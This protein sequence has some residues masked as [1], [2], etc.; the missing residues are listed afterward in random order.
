MSAGGGQAV[1]NAPPGVNNENNVNHVHVGPMLQPPPN[2]RRF[3]NQ[4]PLF[5]VRERLFHALFFKFAV[6][7]ARTFPR[8]VRRFFEFLVLLK[9]L[10]AF[11]VLAY[12]HIAFSRTPT[13]CL[14]HVKDSWPR[15]GILRVEILRN[16]S[17]DY[18]IEQSYA[19]ER[20]LKKDK[21]E[22]TTM[23]GMLT[24]EG[25]I[26]IESSADED[27]NEDE[28]IRDGTDYGNI[29]RVHEEG[30]DDTESRQ[31]IETSYINTGPDLISTD[32]TVDLNATIVATEDLE[33]PSSS[34]WEG[35]M[36]FVDEIEGKK[37]MKTSLEV[38]A[39]N[40]S[41]KD[42]DYILEYSLEYGFLRLSPSA[43]L[44]LKIPVKIVTLDPQ[45]DKC[46]GDTFSRFVLDEFLGYDD[47][48][49]A[50]I[51]TL[52]ENEDNKGYLR[53]VITG[54]HYRF[55]SMLTARSS[56]VAAFFIM[57]VFTVSISMLLRYAHHQ[58]FVFIVDLLQMLEFNVTVTFP[59]APLLT[60]ILALVGM[61][62]IMSEFFN[63]TTTAFYIILIVWIADQ[64]DAICCHTAIAKRHWL[65]FFYLYHFSFYAY[66]YRF[67][68]QYSSLALVT[69]WLFIQHSML[70]FF[71][72]YELPVILQQA[73]L[74]HLLLRTH[75]GM[76]MMG[77]AN[78]AALASG[79]A[80]HDAPGGTGTGTQATPPTTQSTTQTVQNTVQST[81]QTSP[82]V[83]TAQTNT[84]HTGDVISSRSTSTETV[85]AG[86]NTISSVESD[87]APAAPTI[88]SR[89]DK[90]VAAVG[91]VIR[92]EE[93]ATLTNPKAIREGSTGHSTSVGLENE[94]V[95]SSSAAQAVNVSP[96][97]TLD[98]RRN[99]GVGTDQ[100]DPPLLP[101]PSDSSR[102]APRASPEADDLD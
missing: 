77:L 32:D 79:A 66:H 78:I 56:Y 90:H 15:D 80:Y 16:P 65:R 29:T 74:Q 100:G 1:N 30:Q 91:Q 94:Q 12:I 23:L 17:E 46:F 59:A 63:D 99:K 50:S 102:I 69:S 48:L 2:N 31:V 5:S 97:E 85:A 14:N 81:T 64:Y 35:F 34:I 101:E 61:E 96:V 62:A 13:T 47:L 71:H 27:T 82:S 54:E 86:T 42:E 58:I 43:R 98:R 49:M 45:E 8:P 6:A 57:L 93:I 72:H 92:I 67:N 28:Y 9:A 70:Y 19:K 88:D 73:Q 55:V 60:V 68:G 20:R 89:S 95:H 21:E 26:T 39:A 75:R 83:S 37:Y 4:N 40:E 18:T 53:N 11:F 52:A 3:Q 25:F 41:S 33:Q 10:V 22:I 38:P 76:G 87:D 84:T 7:Y 24:T 36:S 51:K 44:R